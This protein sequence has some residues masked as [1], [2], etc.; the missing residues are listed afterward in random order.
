MRVYYLLIRS[1]TRLILAPVIVLMTIGTADAQPGPGGGGYALKFDGIDDYVDVLQFGAIAPTTEVTIEFWQNVDSVKQQLTLSLGGALTNAMH[2]NSPWSDSNVYWRFGNINSGGSLTYLPPEDL[3]VGWHH[4]AFVASQSDNSMRIY[5]NGVLEAS[6][7]GMDPREPD[8][9]NLRI[10]A[11]IPPGSYY[12]GLIDELRI[13]NTARSQMAIQS[14]MN[15]KLNGDEPGLLGYWP[16]D[17]GMGMTASDLAG[18]SDGTLVN[19][20]M[21]VQVPEPAS[22]LLCSVAGML[23]CLRRE[24]RR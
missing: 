13:W 9:A 11:F 3:T 6:K 18:N 21:W 22:L 24:A 7:V 8:G 20:P 14:R 23:L 10:G 12:G 17:E 1:S 2:V 5:R 19:G 16:F 4:F 15:T